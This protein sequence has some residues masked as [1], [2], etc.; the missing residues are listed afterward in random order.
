MWAAFFRAILSAFVSAAQEWKLER[1]YRDALVDNALFDAE[2]KARKASD[3]AIEA[4]RKAGA[5]AT[6]DL[7][8]GKTPSDIKRGNDAKW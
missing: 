6:A 8:G 3:A 7:A 5:T 2:E 4:G 1:D